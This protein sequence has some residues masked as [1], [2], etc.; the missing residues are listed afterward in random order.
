MSTASP[1][2]VVVGFDASPAAEEALD[3][4]A[5]EAELRGAPL[6]IGHSWSM[7]AYDLP[8]IDRGVLSSET[9]A[10]AKELL[11]RAAA[12]V[13]AQHPALEV[14]TELLPEE[15]VEG[16]L[17]LATGAALIVVGSRGHNTLESILLGSVSQ[18]LVTHSPGPVVVVGARSDQQQPTGEPAAHPVVVG[19]A[20]DEASASVDFAFAE[21]RLRGVPLL[22]LR[23]W[24]APQAIPG[25]MAPSPHEQNERN[26]DATERLEALLAPARAANPGVTVRT[27]VG[28]AQPEDML[29][30]ASWQSC[31]VVVGA[32]RKRAR[33]APPVGRVT[34]R[35]LHHAH[36]PVAVVPS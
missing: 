15:P 10:A 35:V 33:F 20:S 21:A 18:G 7:E 14:S 25:H 24:M 19:I 11:D 23:A 34:H 3:W 26:R 2:S 17:R 32:R 6:R 22:A 13:R 12:R 29:V 4:A 9:H 27:E 36:A 8:D 28:V 31:L 5:A 16:V 30:A 1:G